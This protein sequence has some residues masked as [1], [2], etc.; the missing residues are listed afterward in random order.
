MC[1]GSPSPCSACAA[2]YYYYASACGRT[3]PEL[4]FADNNTWACLECS[5]YCVELEMTMYFSDATNQKIYIDMQWSEDLNF[6]VFPYESFQT[7]TIDSKLY[8]L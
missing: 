3:C 2:T 6:T 7:I 4:F 5:V 8:T 1:T